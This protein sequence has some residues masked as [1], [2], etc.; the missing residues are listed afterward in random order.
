MA[1]QGGRR[2]PHAKCQR[3]KRVVLELSWFLKLP[4]VRVKRSALVGQGD[5]GNSWPLSQNYLYP[6]HLHIY[7][8]SV[9]EVWSGD[10]SQLLCPP[11]TPTGMIV[12]KEAEA[13]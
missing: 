2:R 9:R 7:L 10:S 5:E 3:R 4:T 11:G 8:Y 12:K 1:S 13:E 6:P